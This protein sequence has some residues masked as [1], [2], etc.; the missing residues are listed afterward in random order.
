MNYIPVITIDES[1]PLASRQSQVQCLSSWGSK[2]QIDFRWTAFYDST[3]WIVLEVAKDTP[4]EK[5]EGLL[6]HNVYQHE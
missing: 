5:I 1:Y 3:R 2:T 6:S 4:T